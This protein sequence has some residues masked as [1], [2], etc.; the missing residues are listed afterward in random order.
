MAD[1]SALSILE[2]LPQRLRDSPYTVGVA[3]PMTKLTPFISQR[4]CATWRAW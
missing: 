1:L 4:F 3:E 2:R